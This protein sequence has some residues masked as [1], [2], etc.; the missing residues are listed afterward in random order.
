VIVSGG[1]ISPENEG[2]LVL[3][4]GKIVTDG[5]DA[6]DETFGITVDTP[7]LQRHVYVYQW[8]KNTDDD[9]DIYYEMEWSENRPIS[10][11]SNPKSKPYESQ[12]FYSTVMLGEY[13]LALDLIEQLHSFDSDLRFY[14]SYVPVT[15]LN[16]ETADK[17]K[18]TINND[19]YFIYLDEDSEYYTIGDTRIEYE[20]L[21]IGRLEYITVIGKQ[22]GDFLTLYMVKDRYELGKLFNGILKLDEVLTNY[23][24]DF[25]FA[26]WGALF[27]T[28]IPALIAVLITMMNVKKSKKQQNLIKED[29]T[30]MNKNE[31]E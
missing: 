18:M 24:D 12:S 29:N 10:Y 28:G 23:E 7:I 16:Q 17:Y 14:T 27:F 30:Q 20:A 15:G 26:K 9:D 19:A 13:E 1:R 21:D 4:S 2:K 11:R 8:V 22:E 5:Y 31:E 6:T 25:S 3:V